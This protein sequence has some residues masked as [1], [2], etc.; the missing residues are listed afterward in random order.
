MEVSDQAATGG[1]LAAMGTFWL[2]YAVLVIILLVAY[3]KIFEKAGKPGWAAIIPIYNVV[4]LLEIVG[5][6]TWW[7][8]LFFIP[9]VNFVIAILVILDL[10]K[11]FGHG[12]GFAMG[13]LFLPFIFMLILAFGSSKYLGPVGAPAATPAPSTSPPV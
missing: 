9:F 4:V 2:I 8:I 7:V 1:L 13:L 5:R 3:W 6:P 11:V 10:A 12:V